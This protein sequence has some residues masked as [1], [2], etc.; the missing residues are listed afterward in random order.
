M[1]G[2]I[3]LSESMHVEYPIW[4]I[5]MIVCGLILL[6]VTYLLFVA[7]DYI[8]AIILGLICL[9]SIVSGNMLGDFFGTKIVEYKVLIDDSVSLIEFVDKYEILDV[10]GQ[11]YTVKEKE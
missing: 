10:E 5:L 9:T 1:E 6:L 2:V 7:D 11:I 4:A 8:A 3:V